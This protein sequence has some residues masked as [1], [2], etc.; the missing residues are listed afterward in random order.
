MYAFSGFLL[1]KGGMWLNLVVLLG[2]CTGPLFNTTLIIKTLS[3]HYKSAKLRQMHDALFPIFA[4]VFS[5]VRGVLVALVVFYSAW[6]FSTNYTTVDLVWY[7]RVHWGIVSIIMLAGSIPSV[8][9]FL[10]D[11]FGKPV[12]PQPILSQRKKD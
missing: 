6:Q 1:G 3:A 4:V 11:A 12:K 10:G 7:V 8:F 9:S 2:E 5:I